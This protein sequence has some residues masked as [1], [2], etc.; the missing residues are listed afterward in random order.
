MA[1]DDRRRRL[2]LIR[3][4]S[5]ITTEYPTYSQCE[6]A[7]AEAYDLL[8]QAR[9]EGL[10]EN[11]KGKPAKGVRFHIAIGDMV[12]QTT[13][14]RD[15]YDRLCAFVAAHPHTL[16]RLF[17]I[18]CAAAMAAFTGDE[19]ALRLI[20]QDRTTM[21]SRASRP[22]KSPRRSSKDRKQNDPIGPGH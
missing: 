13:M 8:K 15:A 7:T 4:H 17:E 11:V 1:S 5:L 10:L 16:A 6:S 14:A 22:R 3:V 9:A 20:R 19:T 18:G 12:E 2:L 21:A